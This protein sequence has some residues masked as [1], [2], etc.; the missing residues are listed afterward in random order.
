VPVHSRIEALVFGGIVGVGI[1]VVFALVTA[2]L[3]GPRPAAM[4]GALKRGGQR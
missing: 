1:I 3:G 4:L 2:A